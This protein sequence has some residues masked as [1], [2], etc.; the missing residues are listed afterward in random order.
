[1]AIERDSRGTEYQHWHHQAGDLSRS[2]EVAHKHGK[3]AERVMI[4]E[5]TLTLYY[6][7][8]GLTENERRDVE[9]AL[10]RHANLAAK[11]A[12]LCHQFERLSSPDEHRVPSHLVHRW[13]DSIK[14]V[15]KRESTDL[16]QSAA[17]RSSYSLAWGGAV[18]VALAI[19]IGIGV[20]FSGN[21][22]VDPIAENNFAGAQ[23]MVGATVPAS[24]TRGLTLHLQDSEREIARLTADSSGDQTALVIQIIEQ[25]RV[26]ARSAKLNDSANLARLLRA[27]E[28]ILMRLA[29]D[30][31]APADA[32]ALRSQLSFELN[33][34]LTKMAQ[35]TS[36]DSHST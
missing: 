4:N 29:S 1:V 32:A 10:A 19:G 16:Q 8:D 11:Y 3:Q 34:M 20:Y 31:V 21:E 27:F 14:D 26:F 6:Y 18:S 28:P 35:D 9:S 36:N 33:V 22:Q 7:D 25:N 13:Q 17:P 12:E 5:E 24:F 23:A 15:A 2:E 30:D